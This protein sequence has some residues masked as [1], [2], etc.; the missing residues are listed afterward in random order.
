[1][2]N[3][4]KII[5]FIVIVPILLSVVYAGQSKF[6]LL[7]LIPKQK[8]KIC[9][10]LKLTKEEL[11]NLSEEISILIQNAYQQGFKDAVKVKSSGVTV[12]APSISTSMKAREI[13]MRMGWVEVQPKQADNVLV[14][15]RSELFNPLNYSYDSYGELKEDADYQ[16]NI[17]GSNY[18]VY[19]YEI[20]DDLSV[21]QIKH[22]SFSAGND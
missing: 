11:N 21:T 9:G 19:I 3:R 14:V 1:M 20:Y 18:H 5:S 8:H 12:I 4:L 6:D 2:K 17:S 15:V 16:L 7:K 13:R 10:L 22:T